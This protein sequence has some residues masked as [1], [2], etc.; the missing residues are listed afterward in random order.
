MPIMDMHLPTCK[1]RS[2]RFT[3]TIK[4]EFENVFKKRT[5][6][7]SLSQQ[8]WQC[9]EHYR[10]ETKC[11]CNV[12]LHISFLLYSIINRRHFSPLLL[13]S[14]L[15]L[16]PCDKPTRRHRCKRCTWHV[17]AVRRHG[18]TSHWRTKTLNI[19]RFALEYS[20]FD[21]GWRT[22]RVMTG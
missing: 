8:M 6:A 18:H 12:H 5:K 20:G 17:R 22:I 3:L 9:I 11:I 21:H 2:Q 1:S 16:C 13:L 4:N 19:W 10:T 7:F 14:P 15:P